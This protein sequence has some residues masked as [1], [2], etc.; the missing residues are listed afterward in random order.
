MDEAKN[1]MLMEITEGTPIPME[2]LL[3]KEQ[4]CIGCMKSCGYRCGQAGRINEQI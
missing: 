3:C 4:C 2:D 1:L